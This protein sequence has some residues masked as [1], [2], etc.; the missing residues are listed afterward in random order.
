MSNT[1]LTKEGVTSLPICPIGSVNCQVSLGELFDRAVKLSHYIHYLSSEIFNEFVSTFYFPGSENMQN[2][3]QYFLSRNMLIYEN[4]KYVNK[5]DCDIDSDHGIIEW[6]RSKGI[7]NI[8]RL[9]SHCYGQG[10]QPQDQ[11]AQGLIQ[12]DLECLQ[13]SSNI[14][15]KVTYS[16]DH[17]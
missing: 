2:P 13:G 6:L 16:A 9:Q 4:F 5:Y 1:L 11:A 14:V 17:C 7:L 15:S 3:V 10:C 8:I 12:P